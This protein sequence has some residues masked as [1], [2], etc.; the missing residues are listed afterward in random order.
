MFFE[1]SYK[2]SKIYYWNPERGF[3]AFCFNVKRHFRIFEKMHICKNLYYAFPWALF[4]KNE[5]NFSLCF[6]ENLFRPN[7]SYKCGVCVLV[8]LPVEQIIMKRI[9]T[10]YYICW[11]RLNT[12]CN[13]D[14]LAT[15]LYNFRACVP[16]LMLHS[17][18]GYCYEIVKV[19][20]NWSRLLGHTFSYWKTLNRL[21][22]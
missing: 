14:Y 20:N 1:K 13:W 5:N 4:A 19:K 6:R 15:V 9:N 17:W 21:T 12:L 7:P 3:L 22:F 2:R 11:C 10:Y 16:F 18:K 8:L